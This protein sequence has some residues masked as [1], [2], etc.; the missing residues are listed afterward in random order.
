[1]RRQRHQPVHLVARHRAIGIEI[2]L[3]KRCKCP[4]PILGQSVAPAL[5]AVALLACGL[6]STVTATLAGQAVMEGFLRIRLQP[7]LRRL[8][9]RGIAILPAAGV[10]LIY[11]SDGMGELLILT[12]VVL[13]LQL[14]FAVVP[15]VL[16]TAVRR[17]MGALTAQSLMVATAALVAF[18]IVALNL[19]LLWDFSQGAL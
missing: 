15:L 10:T 6:N 18:V 13:S 14:P 3:H 9:T 5:F 19:K 2:G 4:R 7:W 17:K 11:G 12:Q 16:F 1:M 8:V